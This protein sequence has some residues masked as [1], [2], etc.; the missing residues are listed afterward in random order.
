[1][2]VSGLRISWG[3]GRRQPAYSGKAVL[4][5]HFPLQAPDLSEII[6]RVNIAQRA[7]LRPVQRGD[8][9]TRAVLRNVP[10][11]IETNFGV[12]E[13]FGIWAARRE[14]NR[15]PVFP[16]ARTAFAPEVSAQ[17]C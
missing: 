6:E 8:P 2:E 10:R 14:I 5:S 3:D 1:M 7:A 16:A 4:H 13:R 17:H 11:R 9:R 15:S 12:I